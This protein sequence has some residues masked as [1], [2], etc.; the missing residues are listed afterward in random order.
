MNKSKIL[1]EK[2]QRMKESATIRMAKKARKLKVQGKDIISLTLGEPDFDTPDYIKDKACEGLQL[3]HTKYTPV[4]GTL[5]LRQAI[6]RKFAHENQLNYAPDE[7]I[8]SNGA[9]QSLMNIFQSIVN[10]GDEIIIFA[11][12]WVSYFDQIKFSGGIPVIIN[13]TTEQGFKVSPTQLKNAIT[14]NTKAIIY[15]SPCNPSGAVYTQE[16]LNGLAQILK[17][18]PDILVI[19]DEIYEY[20]NY[21]SQHYS[22]AQIEHM[23]DRTA[24]VNGFSKGFAMTGWRLGYL[25]G[26]NWLVEA[27]TKVQGQVTS[28][29][30]AF[31]Q[32]AAAQII[33]EDKLETKKMVDAYLKR[34]DLFVNSLRSIPGLKVNLPTGAFYAFPD[35]SHYF[36][37][38]H[39]ETIIR[40]ADDLAEY[41]LFEAQ[42]GT[43]S[44]SAFG[45]DNCLRL[46]YATSE[47]KLKE[48]TRRIKNALSKLQ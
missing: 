16:E 17:N 25:A 26:P 3:G 33:G 11:P 40:N 1:S 4:P 6:C 9:K 22:M 32:Y 19:S 36:G 8:V 42:V 27:C 41:L 18:Y 37:K 45:N 15:S 13:T 20:I 24:I 14:N 35:V 10:P 7:I 38:S 5:E 44:G 2:I 31:S 30:N 39:S 48:A 21:N 46:S 47:D 23:R 29:A 34:R 28:G 12:Y 43:V